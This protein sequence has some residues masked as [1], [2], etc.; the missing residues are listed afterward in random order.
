MV[1]RA[2]VW[3]RKRGNPA[4]ATGFN[5]YPDYD[6]YAS[7]RGMPGTYLE[8][9]V[10]LP[11]AMMNH[12]AIANL[13]EPDDE[14]ISG[15]RFN[16]HVKILKY[17]PG[18]TLSG[19]VCLDAE[20]GTST[21]ADGVCD[22][23][24][25]AIPNARILIER[26]AFS[27]EGSTDEDSNTYWIP[28]ASVD[29]DDRGDWSAIVPAGKMRITAYAGESDPTLERTR[30][31][32]GHSTRISSTSISLGTGMPVPPPIRSQPCSATSQA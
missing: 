26:D 8:N 30:L 22:A 28:I 6:V 4:P 16:T 29:T 24:D 10:P 1:H 25:E 23:S 21:I 13:Y 9:A 17:Y 18:A 19:S 2:L 14:S 15:Y 11:G 5:Y 12:F 27:G 32:S 7:T 20:A 31:T 3:P